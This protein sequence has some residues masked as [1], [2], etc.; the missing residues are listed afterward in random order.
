MSLQKGTAQLKIIQSYISNPQ[1]NQKI[2]SQ[3]QQKSLQAKT[4]NTKENQE[5][6]NDENCITQY[7][8]YG[9]TE[10]T[11][12]EYIKQIKR[13]KIAIQFKEDQENDH[14]RLQ[15][16]QSD[17]LN[18]QVPLELNGFGMMEQS[19]YSEHEEEEEDDYYNQGKNDV[20]MQTHELFK[21]ILLHLIYKN[22]NEEEQS[23]SKNQIQEEEEQKNLDR[24]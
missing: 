3:N 10:E 9:F 5:N 14:I 21:Q 4:Q 13:E 7:Y 12:K 23:Q 22:D 19:D 2:S 18:Y 6:Q 20:E 1:P 8:N 24:G 16:V 15:Q 11:Y 17:K